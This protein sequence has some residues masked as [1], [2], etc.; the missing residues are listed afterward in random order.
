MFKGSYFYARTIAVAQMLVNNL[1]WVY[2]M[3]RKS[4]EIYE[5]AVSC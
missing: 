5:V 3:S 2:L 4:L 1:F